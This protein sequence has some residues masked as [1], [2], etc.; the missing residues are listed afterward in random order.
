MK[1]YDVRTKTEKQ[2]PRKLID[3]NAREQ[4]DIAAA[5]AAAAVA[6]AA[7]DTAVDAAVVVNTAAE[8]FAAAAKKSFEKIAGPADLDRNFSRHSW[9]PQTKTWCAG[10]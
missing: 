3:E 9:A 8:V 6:A 7:V 2:D 4:E 10:P 5:A 1:M